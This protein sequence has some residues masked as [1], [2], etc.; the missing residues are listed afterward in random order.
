MPS[1]YNDREMKPGAVCWCCRVKLPARYGMVCHDCKGHAC[2]CG[3]GPLH[4]PEHCPAKCKISS[5]SPAS[6]T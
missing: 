1:E 3:R 4:C 5:G 6:A 2:S